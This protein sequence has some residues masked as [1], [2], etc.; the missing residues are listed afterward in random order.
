MFFI[1]QILVFHDIGFISGNTSFSHSVFSQSFFKRLSVRDFLR[2]QCEKVEVVSITAQKLIVKGGGKKL[3][4]KMYS[5]LSKARLS[6]HHSTMT[7]KVKSVEP[8]DF[9]S[10]W[11]MISRWDIIASISL[12]SPKTRKGTLMIKK[13]VSRQYDV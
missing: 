11:T 9:M 4:E 8:R 12:K 5:V 1:N 10:I 2:W 13:N 3:A 7:K 6:E